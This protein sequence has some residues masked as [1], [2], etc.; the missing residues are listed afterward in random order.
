MIKADFEFEGIR[1]NEKLNR[2]I[3]SKIKDDNKYILFLDEIQHVKHFE[4]VLASFKV[5][6]NCSIFVTGSNSKLLSSELAALLVGRCIE[7]KILQFK[8]Q[9]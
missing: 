5:T 9:N 4:K 8:I 1:T 6:L 7:F 3:K 2:Y